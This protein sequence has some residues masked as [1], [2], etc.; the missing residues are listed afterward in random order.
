MS[1]NDSI[2]LMAS[3]IPLCSGI[4]LQIHL[5]KLL[6]PG[7]FHAQYLVPCYLQNIPIRAPQPLSFGLITI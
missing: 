4:S 7:P 2:H 5:S 6:T 3:L 1:V